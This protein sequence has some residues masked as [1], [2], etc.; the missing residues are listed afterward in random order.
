MKRIWGAKK[1][2]TATTTTTKRIPNNSR[3]SIGI[4]L[5]DLQHSSLS[6]SLSVFLL[7]LSLCLC[8]HCIAIFDRDGP[9]V[10]PG[11]RSWVRSPG[12]GS[13][14]RGVL[15]V[16]DSVAS[17]GR[18]HER[19]DP[20]AATARYFSIRRSAQPLCCIFEV[21]CIVYLPDPRW[22]N[23]K[24]ASS[25]RGSHEDPAL[26]SWRI[27]CRQGHSRNGGNASSFPK[28]DRD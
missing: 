10:Q 24:V 1:P 19:P 4:V 15:L 26:A 28:R 3:E 16:R 6:L 5:D 18:V 8:T 9:S 7:S 2:A 13:L 14:R 21:A 11:A 20:R 23:R 22:D 17:G 25:P 27:R 12:D